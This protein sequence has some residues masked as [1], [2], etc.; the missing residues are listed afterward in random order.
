MDEAFLITERG[1]PTSPFA[2]PAIRSLNWGTL[3]LPLRVDRKG[4]L[5][6][7]LVVAETPVAQWSGQNERTREDAELARHG[8]AIRVQRRSRRA[9]AGSAAPARTTNMAVSTP[10]SAQSIP[11]RR[12][13]DDTYAYQGESLAT[14]P[15]ESLSGK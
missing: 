9:N 14:P 13:G 8:S 6:S 7:P 15:S 5:S 2:M 11:S 4:R 3:Q 1:E 10:A 12:A